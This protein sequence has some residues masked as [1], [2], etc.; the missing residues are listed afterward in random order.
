M[1]QHN[2]ISLQQAVEE[3][4]LTVAPE[5]PLAEVIRLM[6]QDWTTSCILEEE[7]KNSPNSLV[8][9]HHSCV[10]AIANSQLEGI[11]TEQALV[12][13]ISSGRNIIGVTLAEVMSRNVITLTSDSSQDSP[14][15]IFAALKLFHQYRIR[16][17]PIIDE[18][19]RLL[20]VVTHSSLRQVLR[21]ADL[22]KLRTVS[23]VMTRAIHAV[24]T[25]SVLSVAQLMADYQVSGIPIVELAEGE[26][27][28]YPRGII[29]ERDIVQ[30][31]LLELNLAE[32]R[33]KD[34]MSTPLHLAKPEDSLWQVSQ[35]MNRYLLRR[36]VVAGEQG[37]LLGI[38]TQSSLLGAIDLKDLQDSL[39]I[40]QTQVLQLEQEKTR[41][42]QR[43]NLELT[44][45]VSQQ[46]QELRE[47]ADREQLV[48]E[49]ALRI[50]ESLDL[51]AILQSTVCE[52][53]QLINA[54]RVLIYRFEPD[55]SG[56]VTTEAVSS[57]EW[58]ILGRL[59]KDSCFE[60]AWIEPYQQ[61]HVFSLADVEQGGLSPCHLEFLQSF[62]VRA[63]VA[64]PILLNEESSATERL[65]GLLIVHQCS[66]IRNWQEPEI[67]LLQRL[68]IQVAIAIQ[69]GE[70]Y[71]QAQIELEQ[72]RQA[73]AEL[74][75][76]EARFRMMANTSPVMIWMAGTDKQCT[77]F[78]QTWLN[79]TGRTLEQELGN[80]WLDGVND[81][82]KQRCWERYLA[83]FNNREEFV[84][85]YRLRSADGEYRW[86]LDRGI[87]RFAANGEF[88]G[89][90]GSCIDIGDRKQAEE[91]LKE[92]EELFRVLVTSAPVGIFQTDIWG[93]CVYVNP[94]WQEM[95]GLSQ[96]KALGIGW[97]EALH[98][99]DR[100][101]VFS[102]W[103]HATET[104]QEFNSEYRFLTPQGKVTWVSGQA[105]PLYDHE[106]Q[107]SGYL[108]TLN[109]ISSRKQ[110][111]E[112]LQEQEAQLRTALDAAAMGTWIW[113]ISTNEVILSERSQTIF[114]F[115]P[116]EFS[117]T[118]D[119]VLTLIPPE[120]LEEINQQAAKGIKSGRLY[121]IETRLN[122]SQNKQ[123]WLAARGH[124]LLDSEGL[125]WRMIG[126]VA[127][128]TE[129]KHLAEKSLRHQRLDSLGSLAGGV[130]HDLNNILTPILMSVQLLPVTLTQIDPRSREI[131]RMLENN[132]KRGSALVQQVLSFARGIE[133]KRGVVQVKHLIRDI[134]QIAVET[135]PKGIRI[136]T[137]VSSDLWAVCG[138]ATQI[139]QVLLN[140]V[141]NARDA[142]PEGGLLNISASNL[143]LDATYVQEYPQ[144]EVGSYVTISIEDTGV[145]I[146][147]ND[148]KQIFEP[149][150][151]TKEAMGG[152][153]L[154]LATVLNI[155]ESHGGFVDVVSEVDRGTQ[156]NIMIPAAESSAPESGAILAIPKGNNELVLVVD[157]EAT[158]RE[159]TQAS[160]ET[161][162]YRVLT[163]NDGIEAIAAYVQNQAEIEVVLMNMM[164]PAMDGT[165]A[166]RTLQKINPQVKIIAISGRNFTK[167]AFSD[168]KVEIKSF[169][170]KPY[171]TQA[172]LQTIT[173]VVNS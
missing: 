135:F 62:Q 35:Q 124:I 152:T 82:D 128:I 16:H 154:G 68:T 44:N 138:D 20:G 123:R 23:E 73:E 47:Q 15:D 81:D 137:N 19:N 119:A 79:F 167:E 4:L 77:F 30:F 141:I 150:F 54:D 51:S 5:T 65:W 149:F 24:P 52:V 36:L 107:I 97:A 114:G 140:L 99:Q 66:G 43:R 89:Y 108:G 60:P 42:L 67:E 134:Y 116:G 172:L 165:T 110:A 37:E 130:A 87:P 70:L 2:S 103:H 171:S 46:A 49:V 111:E 158:I 55:W 153:G 168:L 80:G 85:E 56:I 8:S 102:E 7:A 18:R 34:V 58:S 64:I 69:Q 14:Q 74:R 121:E 104:E 31:Q 98:P 101:R 164:M 91:N 48:A 57:S 156:F 148:I 163:A 63:N 159:I 3:E 145:G 29:T 115:S 78:N 169:L 22:L 27:L 13:I 10:L 75:E 166:I 11:F 28:L 120:D 131:I 61:G 92:R 50:R 6:S 105:I 132:V 33:A 38:I 127:D 26:D 71:Q 109:D 117:G 90:I 143:L 32:I 94:R 83:S 139:H 76:S 12:K 95:T 155:I 112:T 100:D 162:N 133:G 161:H 93:A 146:P 39:E 40:L 25:A 88:A 129:K 170:A 118:L 86:I 125:P 136:Q 113:D 21:S 9:I 144:A 1:P 59:I 41:S 96:K 142:M 122:I 84:L 45:Q 72:R 126:V 173:D 157:D 160:L 151:T 106:G 53:R 17:L 147:P